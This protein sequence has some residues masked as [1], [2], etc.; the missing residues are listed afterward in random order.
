MPRLVLALV[1]LAL[2]APG[3]GSAF[4]KTERQIQMSDG[5]MIA[6]TY[7]V[8][9]GAPPSGGWA[10]VMMLHGLGETRTSSA[11]AV[12]MSVNDLAELYVVPQGYA[13]LTFD[14]RGHGQSGGLVSIDGPREIQD[15]RELFNWLAMQAPNVNPSRIGA[16]GYSYGG[17]AV[18]RA[19]A[20]GVPFAAIEVATAWTDLY[21]ALAPQELARSGVVLGFWQSIMARAAPEVEPIVQDLLAGQNLDLA[22]AYAAQRSTRSLLGQIRIPT[23]LLQGRRDFAFDLDQALAAYA[24]L[25]GPKRLYVSD[26]GHMPSP[27]PRGELKKVMPTARLWFDRFLKGLPNGIDKPPFVEVAP[28]PWTGRIFSYRGLPARRTLTL[29]FSGSA[30]IGSTGKISRTRPRLRKR[31]E[32]FGAP[33]LRV[34]LSS[35]SGW[36][37]VVAVLSALTPG[38]KQIVVSAG[39]ARVGLTGRAKRITIRLI[40]Q[41]TNVPPRARLRLTIAATSTAQNQGNLLYLTGVPRSAHLDVGS[42][43]LAL[44]VL[45]KPISR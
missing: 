20:E 41:A 33:I 19:A 40:S 21:S 12:G 23:F 9:D 27:L 7:Y 18:W 10:A 28:D 5:V 38:G 15:V 30:S 45:S 16:F 35:S 44:P 31:L 13:V 43:S 14:A 39:G 22:R 11:N 37:H 25:N 6:A 32:T 17:G 2:V 1:A 42:A 36:P 8:P 29:R 24:R 26:F 34:S 4:S 3:T